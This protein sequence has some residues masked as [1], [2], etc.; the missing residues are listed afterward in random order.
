MSIYPFQINLANKACSVHLTLGTAALR[1]AAISGSF[2]RLFI[3]PWTVRTGQPGW[4]PLPSPPH[5]QVSPTGTMAQAV[6]Q[7]RGRSGDLEIAR[8]ADSLES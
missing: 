3:F 5:T 2:L 4:A 8:H 1:R 7:L 6:G